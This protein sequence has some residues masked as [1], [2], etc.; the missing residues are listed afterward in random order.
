[1]FWGPPEQGRELEEGV[2]ILRGVDRAGLS[3]KVTFEQ[4]PRRGEGGSH[5][6]LGGRAVIKARGGGGERRGPVGD[7]V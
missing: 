3:D 4:K 6:A 5:E 2:A 7:K 1:M